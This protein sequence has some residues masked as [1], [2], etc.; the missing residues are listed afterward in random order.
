MADSASY[1]STLLRKINMNMKIIDNII[2]KWHCN[3]DYVMEMML[4]IQDEYHYLP[5]PALERI[6]LKT[7]KPLSRLY[8]IATFYKSFSLKPRAKYEIRVC[9]GT[10]C[11]V[12]GADMLIDTLQRAL[13]INI[14]DTT[15]DGKFS[16]EGFSC[17]GCCNLAPALI[18][19]ND[20]YGH[21]KNTDIPRLLAKYKGAER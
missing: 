13:G 3:P 11:H 15:A 7:K 16:L 5:Q 14:G 20:L 12:E 21:V 2:E 4:D 19:G 18:I 10:A 6:T 8:H 9:L 1:F 17:L